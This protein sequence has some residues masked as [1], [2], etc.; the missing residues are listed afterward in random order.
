MWHLKDKNVAYFTVLREKGGN[1]QNGKNKGR[2]GAKDKDNDSQ[3][4]FHEA[5]PL[6]LETMA[7][8]FVNQFSNFTFQ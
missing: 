3:L 8:L 1:L 6:V 4:N 5:F 2:K 7:T